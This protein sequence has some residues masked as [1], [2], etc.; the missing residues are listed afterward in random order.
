MI[1]G[2]S[3]AKLVDLYI[4]I[5]MCMGLD[6]ASRGY[7]YPLPPLS[8]FDQSLLGNHPIVA[9][10]FSLKAVKKL[11]VQMLGEAR[12]GPG[13]A[14]ALRKAFMKEGTANGRS[15]TITTECTGP[16]EVLDKENPCPYCGITREDVLNDTANWEYKDDMFTSRAVDK[17]NSLSR[18]IEEEQTEEGQVGTWKSTQGKG[19]SDQSC[20][21]EPYHNNQTD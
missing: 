14:N 10:L 20:S 15:I 3:G 2:T 5:F 8:I 4:C 9:G 7:H 18:E 6:E 12:F 17:Y 21:H 19:A 16:H 11:K 1:L 13:V